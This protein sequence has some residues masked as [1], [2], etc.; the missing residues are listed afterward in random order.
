[1]R[2]N[3]APS[4]LN[5]HTVKHVSHVWFIEPP[6]SNGVLTSEGIQKIKGH[7]YV[8]GTYTALDLCLNSGWQ[9]LTE[10]FLPIWL[11]PNLVTALGGGFALLS[12]LC[13][14]H[15]SFDMVT[16]DIPGWVLVVNGMCLI[17]YYTLDC[18]DGKQARR[19]N[20]SSPLGQLFDHGVDCLAN[21]SHL[22]LM[23][24]I[25][26][27]SGPHY[28]ILQSSLQLGF[29]QAQFEEYYTGS[30]PHAAGN[31]GT[32]EILYGMA[33]WSICTGLGIL[34]RSIYD[35]DV[36]WLQLDRAYKIPLAKFILCADHETCQT[37]ALQVR[38]IIVLGWVYGF[39]GLSIL[40]FLRLFAVIGSSSPRV[41]GSA[42]SKMTSPLLLCAL[43]LIATPLSNKSLGGIRYP[44]L[45]IGLC[46]CLITIKLVVFGMARMAY[47]SIQIVD[48]T[49]IA[50]IAWLHHQA[51]DQYWRQLL[52]PLATVGYMSRL[53]WWTKEA[54]NPLCKHLNVKLFR[55]PSSP[56]AK[57]KSI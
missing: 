17:V 20:S 54:V 53:I 48:L 34:D 26:G 14:S 25:L 13:T 39:F 31:V 21:L 41:V 38:H 3:N 40:S 5:D 6:T 52:Y 2:N 35:K 37:G 22:S 16:G 49:P 28:M 30:L 36:P 44:S 45:A 11:A 24:A 8:A 15:Y 19:T 29:F 50:I 1:M 57:M 7:Q 56:V 12:Y 18:M 55:I 42:L 27:L 9:Y 32:T 47:A 51:P 33:L 43:A 4:H 23:Q 10:T 46:F